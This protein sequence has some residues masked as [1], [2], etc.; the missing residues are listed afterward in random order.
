VNFI[1]NSAHSRRVLGVLLALVLGLAAGAPWA[2][3]VAAAQKQEETSASAGG[4]PAKAAQDPH[5]YVHQGLVI[6]LQAKPTDGEAD[7]ALTAGEL[8]DIA[9]RIT[10]ESTGEPV[11]GALPGAWM[12]LAQVLGGQ[13]GVQQKSCKDKIALYLQGAIGIRPI[14]DMNSYFVL[15][16]NKEPSISVVDPVV[17]MMGM[18][19]TFARVPLK[20]PGTDW[21]L[22]DG[23]KRLFVTLPTAG[24]VAVVET[25]HFKLETYV[26]AGTRPT[27]AAL[28][29]DGR[30]LW[31][32][33]DAEDPEKSGVTVIDTDTLELVAQVP[34]GAGHHEIAFSTDSRHAFVSNRDGGT[35]SVVDVQG[36]RK[37]QDVATGPLPISLDYSTTAQA[38][39]V[40]DGKDGSVS[41]LGP[42]LGVAKRIPLE[43]GLGP[44]GI[45]QDGRYVLV[46]N[47]GADAVF[48]I[49]T[50]DNELM[51]RIEILGK[52]YQLA[53]SE[54]FAYVR[55][56]ESERV[57]MINV[58][59]LNEATEPAVLSF[60]AGG[61]A[62]AGAGDLPVAGSIA[63][64]PG[65]GAVF[66]VNPADNTTYYYHEGMNAPSSNYQ[67]RGA[68]A[69]AVMV[70]DRSLK[71]TEPGLYTGKVK[72][73]AAGQ[74][75]VA[76]MLETPRVLHCFPLEVKDN[77][78]LRR[79]RPALSVEYLQEARVLPAGK[80]LALRFRLRDST[81]GAPRPG[82][83]DVKVMYFLAPGRG[84]TEVAAR[85][86]GDG[87]YQVDLPLR[88][89]GAYYVYVAVPSQGIGYTDL[90]YLS[91]R[92]A[93]PSARG[94]LTQAESG[95]S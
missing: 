78:R 67:S 19:S 40:A 35:V 2:G 3:E 46:L 26:D 36:L 7:E 70:V 15:M 83:R 31:V 49:D 12:D 47:P 48:V 50:A 53:F 21:A 62:P 55:A 66:V 90:I 32:G 34:T 20:R 44:L 13:P 81:N 65:E 5:R 85:E 16:L 54:T 24:Q 84:R 59:T 76:L 33:N 77:P 27:R 94:A 11:R 8:S 29:P 17:S 41:V 74:Y 92:A 87:V 6:E 23:R 61:A 14:V 68:S 63:I 30:Y 58:D 80:T 91:L 18:T 79:D 95:G 42:D 38:L 28:Q 22:S 89:R 45:T 82:L 57:S 69:R 1:G 72:P 86:I 10:S 37:L 39:Y 43:P 4:D 52:P 75:D 71:E 60:V 73:P 88:Q 9:F 64:A 51:H 56:L 25:D 93:P